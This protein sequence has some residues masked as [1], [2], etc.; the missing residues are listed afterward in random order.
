MATIY[1]WLEKAGFNFQTGEIIYQS[2]TEDCYAPGWGDPFSARSMPVE[3]LHQEFD[4]SFGSPQCPR[5][6]AR[7]GDFVY[8]PSQYDGSTSL[9]KVNVNP[10]FYLDINHPTPYPGGG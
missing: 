1:T 9:A 6:F 4:D 5:F 10:F 7:C 2:V 8:F 3:V